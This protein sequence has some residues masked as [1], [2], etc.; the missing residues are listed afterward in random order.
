[1]KTVPKYITAVVVKD[2]FEDRKPADYTSK[3]AILAYSALK[4]VTAG[5]AGK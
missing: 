1:L 4:S 3:N 2:F 5:I